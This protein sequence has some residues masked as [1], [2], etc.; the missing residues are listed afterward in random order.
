MIVVVK[1]REKSPLL[2]PLAQY[3][4]PVC[5][6]LFLR[7]DKM[8][9]LSGFLLF[10]TT[11]QPHLILYPL[12]YLRHR[13]KFLSNYHK[14]YSLPAEVTHQ[15]VVV[16]SGIQIVRFHLNGEIFYVLSW[17]LFCQIFLGNKS[18]LFLC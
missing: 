10:L 18:P 13:L 1:F 6:S 17:P 4:H 9:H 16:T 12:D 11:P 3:H 7:T 15:S 2:V 8:N 5:G 14:L